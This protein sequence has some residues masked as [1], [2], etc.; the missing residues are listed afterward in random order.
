[1][2]NKDAR[3]VV[4]GTGG[5]IAGTAASAADHTGYT[6][7]R[8]GV[9]QLLAPLGPGVDT[10]V[11]AEQV[12]Q[13]DSKDMDAAG[14]QRLA[15]RVAH[16]LARDEVQG[17]VITHGTDTLEETAYFLH[18]AVAPRKPVVMT[19]AMRPATALQT[20]G[21]QN[22]RDALTV[23]RWPGAGGVVAVVAGQVIGAADLRKVHTY[24]LD[25]FSAGDAGPIAQVEQGRL[26]VHR[27]WP[28]GE[29]APCDEVLRAD[30]AHWPWVAVV[31]SHAGA[32][33][34]LVDALVGAG[35]RGLVVAATG[36]G[37]VHAALGP[38]LQ[39]AAEA[40]VPVVRSTRCVNGALVGDGADGIGAED[41]AG[42][43][44]LAGTGA[45]TP[46]QARI[47]LML[48]LLACRS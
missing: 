25:A 47:E 3:V 20:D 22:L 26:R 39:R 8:L 31:M 28:L 1:M 38:A 44:L 37:T 18:R 42:W 27:A 14:W 16:H 2:Q 36:N 24:R 11:E 40:G 29:G 41:P 32:D 19:A 17:V 34:R 46:V 10:A 13:L 9:V 23:V 30:P 48:R 5:T 4:L 43:P 21:P 33:A 6:A 45:L 7:A 12:L 35:V 15:A